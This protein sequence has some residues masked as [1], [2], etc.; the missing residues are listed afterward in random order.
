MKAIDPILHADEEEY[1]A[2]VKPRKQANNRVAEKYWS[3]D[4][5]GAARKKQFKQRKQ[6]E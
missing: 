5:I 2:P 3:D 1:D 6:Q 4:G